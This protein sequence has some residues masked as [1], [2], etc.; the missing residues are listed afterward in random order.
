MS[1]KKKGEI[2]LKEAPNDVPHQ[3]EKITVYK[4]R[5]ESRE[6]IE[7]KDIKTGQCHY[8]GGIIIAV[9]RRTPQ[10]IMTQP[11]RHE[12]DFP[13]DWTRQQCFDDFDSEGQKAAML[14]QQ[15]QHEAAMAQRQQVVG[16]KNMPNGGPELLGPKGKPMQA[17]RRQRR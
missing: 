6:V 4:E 17:K 5:T 7:F 2:E 8:K 13:A 12:F 15:R 14:W 10:G 3:W 9:Q 1:E 11:V 16:A